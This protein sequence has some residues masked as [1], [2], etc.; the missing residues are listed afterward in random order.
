MTL[1]QFVRKHG[2]RIKYII[3]STVDGLEQ[4]AWEL[5]PDELEDWVMNVERLYLWA[6][7]E[8]VEEALV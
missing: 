1:A 6:Q 2:S 7:E 4:L 3:S 8:G 5:E